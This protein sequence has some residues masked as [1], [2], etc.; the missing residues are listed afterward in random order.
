VVIVAETFSGNAHRLV[1]PVVGPTAARTAAAGYGLVPN[2]CPDREEE[3]TARADAIADTTNIAHIVAANLAQILGRTRIYAGLASAQLAQ[4]EAQTL[5][6]NPIVLGDSAYLKLAAFDGRGKLR[7]SSAQSRIEPEMAGLVREYLRK[8]IPFGSSTAMLVGRPAVDDGNAWRVPLLVPISG[9]SRDRGFLAGIL[10]LGYFLKLYQEVKLGSGGR[11]EILGD[12]GYQ[13]VEST[14]LN[15][16]GG[17]GSGRVGVFQ[18]FAEWQGGSGIIRRP[19]EA[20][21]TLVSF[22]R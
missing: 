3:I 20:S 1:S 10:D 16:F 14:G 21:Q 4:Q 7:F 12:D 8:P 5:L 17:Q 13:L 18:F 19:D 9:S 22:G 6:P 11:I 15:T 2:A